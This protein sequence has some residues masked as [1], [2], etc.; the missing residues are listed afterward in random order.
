[1]KYSIAGTLA[2]L[3]LASTA[4][5]ADNMAAPAV[6]AESAQLDFFLGNWNCNG[7]AFASATGPEHASVATVHA[8]KAIGGR[9]QHV[10]YD[11]T[12]TAANPA[13]YHVG[14]YWGY[15]AGKKNFVQF[16]ADGFGGYCN[17]TSAGWSGDTLIFEGTGNGDGKQFGA[18]DTFTRKAANEFVHSGEMQGD[19]KKW[20]KTDEETCKRAK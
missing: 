1:M 17:Q 9:W 10:T 7:K 15:D 12:K 16:C 5:F 6:P 11:E 19:D 20:V 13:P 14:V 3:A 8:A 4:A 2:V 18:R